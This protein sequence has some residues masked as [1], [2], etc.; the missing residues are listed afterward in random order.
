M[1]YAEETA[2]MSASHRLDRLDPVDAPASPNGAFPGHRLRLTPLAPGILCL[3]L[4]AT[5]PRAIAGDLTVAWNGAGPASSTSYRVFIGERPGIYDRVV[6]AGTSLSAT[7]TDLEDGRVHYFAVKAV[8]L[9][10]HESPDFSSELACMARPRVES[11]RAPELSA[12]GAGWVSL[13]GANFDRDIQVRSKDPDLRVRGVVLESEGSLSVFVEASAGA[14]GGAVTVSAETFSLLNPCRRADVFFQRRPQAADVDGSGAVDEADVR[15]V[16]AAIGS[17]RGESPYT[18]AADVDADGLVDGR[19]LD[20]VLSLLK[21]APRTASPAA[22]SAP[23]AGA[24]AHS[25]SR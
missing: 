12:G 9:A 11:V 3:V 23:A 18:T 20:H 24:P 14:P 5:T 25:S 21:A 10:G 6:E 4:A 13:R 19:D 7:V 1:R 8:D 17:R 22:A 2:L 15:A 16:S